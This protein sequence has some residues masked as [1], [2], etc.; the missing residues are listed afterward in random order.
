MANMISQ[1]M[2]HSPPNLLWTAP[3][4]AL[5]AAAVAAALSTPAGIPLALAALLGPDITLAGG[6]AGHGR[7]RAERVRAYNAAHR[8][9]GPV[10]VAAAGLLVPSLLAVAA[11]WAAHIAMDRTAG[12]GLRGADGWQRR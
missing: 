5:L 6:F 11:G 2:P 8:F 9:A 10:L 7:L 3:F 4:L 12:F 1:P